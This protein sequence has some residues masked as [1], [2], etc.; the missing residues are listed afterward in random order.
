MDFYYDFYSGIIDKSAPIDEV[1][2]N[3]YNGGNKNYKIII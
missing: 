3:L 1:S 2:K